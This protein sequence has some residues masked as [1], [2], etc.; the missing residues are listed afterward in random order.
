MITHE[1]SLENFKDQL[2]YALDN[3]TSHGIKPEDI[4]HIVMGGLGGSGIGAR[5]A[6]NFFYELSDK[7]IEVVSDYH[8]PN[9]IGN[10]TL[11]ILASYSGETEE[12]LSMLAEGLQANCKIVT[13]SSG[14]ILAEISEENQFKTYAVPEGYQPRMAFGFSSAINFLILADLLGIDNITDEFKHTIKTYENGNDWKES[15]QRMLNYFDAKVKNKFV[16]VADRNAEPTATRFAQQIQENAKLEAFVNVLP[17]N[18]HNVLETYYSALPSNFVLLDGNSNE[19]VTQRF[20]FLK[21][22]LKENNIPFVTI[23][24]DGA[25]ISEIYKTVHI[26]DWFSILLSNKVGADNMQVKNITE[27]KKYLSK[28]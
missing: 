25:V 14:G 19:R 4:D 3:Y 1:E 13:I 8:L 9:Y 18:N 28:N 27:L 12:T 20:N 5:F 24:F 26:L 21:G 10:R 2:Q 22:V 11:L 17:E 16:I 23:N 6:K 15:A 7:S